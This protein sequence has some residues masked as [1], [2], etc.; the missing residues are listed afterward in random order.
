VF[1][2]IRQLEVD[3][4]RLIVLAATVAAFAG[5]A[6]W[7]LVG[8]LLGAATPEL[9]IVCSGL[10]FY[11]VASAPRRIMNSRRLSQSREAVFLATVSAASARVVGSRNRVIIMLRSR[12]NQVS[13]A[14]ASVRRSLYLG[15]AA[16][17][18]V[19]KASSRLASYS[20]STALLRAGLP[21]VSVNEG[22]EE[23]LGLETSGQMA[24]ETKLPIF[25][26]A[27]FFT[28]IMLLLYAVFSHVTAPE[29][30]V[31]LVA[32]EVI[33]LDIAFYVCS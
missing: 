4:A 21:S 16:D 7:F 14:L 5:L 13:E 12:D 23:S 27:A 6:V 24:A 11:I 3:P 9:D 1:T 30:M 33:I 32:L 10:V 31:E 25:M 15:A 17:E 26:T 8:D 2:S 18:A 22:G 29:R 20:A 28:P 19:S